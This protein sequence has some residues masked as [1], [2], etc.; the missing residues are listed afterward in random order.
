MTEEV[1]LSDDPESTTTDVRCTII[2]CIKHIRRYGEK[3]LPKDIWMKILYYALKGLECDKNHLDISQ[4]RCLY[5]YL[6]DKD[7]TDPYIKQFMKECH[8]EIHL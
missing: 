5:A 8:D 4:R 3:R 6:K 2:A 7:I 1:L